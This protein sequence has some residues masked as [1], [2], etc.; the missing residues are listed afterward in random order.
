MAVYNRMPV[1]IQLDTWQAALLE[2]FPF[3]EEDWI[4]NHD[5]LVGIKL[6]RSAL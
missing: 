6:A 3:L 2:R 1:T 5:V 4:T